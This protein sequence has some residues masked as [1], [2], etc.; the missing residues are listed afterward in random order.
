MIQRTDSQAKE[1]LS[2]LVEA[3]LK[4]DEVV[5]S[6]AGCPV[7]K[8]VRIEREMQTREPGGLTSLILHDDFDS[9]DETI[10]RDFER[11]TT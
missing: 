11:G 9:T 8:I 3:V 5:L 1:Q 2:A 10:I 4:A 7:V 6:R